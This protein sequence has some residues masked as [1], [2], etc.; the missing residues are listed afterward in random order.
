MNN[1]TRILIGFIAIKCLLQFLLLSPDYDLHRDEYLHLN[2]ASHLAWGFQSVPPFTSW[3]SFLIQSLG[4]S[5]FWVKFFPTLYGVLTIYIVWKAIETLNGDRFALILGATCVLFSALL[6]LNTL[7]QPNSFDVLSW[8]MLYFICLKYFKTEQTK[9]LIIGAVVGAI[10]FLNKYN[11]V[12]LLMGFMPAVLVSEQRKMFLQPRLYIALLIGLIITAPNLWWQYAHGF[13]VAHHLK[14]LADTQLVHVDRLG[15]LKSQLLFY[16]GSLF[17]ILGALYAL[18]FY[19]PFDRY[20]PFFFSFFFTLAAFLYFKA[21][22]YY[23]IGIYPIYIAFGSVYV[24]ELLKNRWQRYGQ[25]LAIALPLLLFIPIYQVAFPNKSPEYIIQ[26]NEYYK[27]WGLLR[28]EDGKDHLL[29]QDFADMLGWKELAFKV[30]SIYATLPN[31]TRTLILCDNYGQAGAINYY[32]HRNLK[33][34]S[35][36]TDYLYWFD[37]S[38]RYDNLIR[39]KSRSDATEELTES[40]PFFQNS[41]LADS[42]SNPYAREVGTLIFAFTGAKIDIRER[43]QNEIDEKK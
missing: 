25:A 28:W 26:H 8:T 43:I 6:R 35:F 34:V 21:K 9:W 38:H 17:V 18:V 4:N 24:S 14:E 1:N 20:R 41:S 7:Y 12:F 39:I 19:K 16:V 15:F 37:L 30:D 13:P 40:S 3:T 42:I 5:V 2:Q 11:I 31:Q 27:K 32:T 29:P 10:G 23:A 36:S 33:A 22:D